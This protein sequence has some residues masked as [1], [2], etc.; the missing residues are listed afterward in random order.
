MDEF[1]AVLNDFQAGENLQY[2]QKQ[3]SVL[4]FLKD[5]ELMARTIFRFGNLILREGK[6]V[7]FLADDLSDACISMEQADKNKQLIRI[8]IFLL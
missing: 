6:D 1:L 2:L 7:V 4:P 3:L 5:P 8:L